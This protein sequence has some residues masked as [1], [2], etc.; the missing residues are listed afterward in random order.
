[1]RVWLL[2]IIIFFILFGVFVRAGI[3]VAEIRPGADLHSIESY[4]AAPL[5]LIHP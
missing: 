2:P 4:R 5:G 3:S 1:M